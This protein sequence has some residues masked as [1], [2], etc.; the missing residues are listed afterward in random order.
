MSLNTLALIGLGPLGAFVS[1]A[2]ARVL[3]IQ[4]AIA[5]TASV[6][7]LYLVATLL[8]GPARRAWAAIP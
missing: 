7:L 2:M 6:M 1:A 5:A 3:P 4:V 8:I